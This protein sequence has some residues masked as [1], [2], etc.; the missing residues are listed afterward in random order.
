MSRDYKRLKPEE[1]QRIREMS[2]KGMTNTEIIKRT[3]RAR[4]TILKAIRGELLP[5]KK[6]FDMR[7]TV[8][9]AATGFPALR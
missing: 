4:N 5:A 2:A 8:N 9:A 7:C 6:R 1:I 3:G